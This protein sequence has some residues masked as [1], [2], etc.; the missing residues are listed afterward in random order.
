MEQF[1]SSEEESSRVSMG[2]SFEFGTS[3][4]WAV[5][6]QTKRCISP[7]SSVYDAV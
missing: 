5:N 6:R 7:V 3:D 1:D 4:I 2:S